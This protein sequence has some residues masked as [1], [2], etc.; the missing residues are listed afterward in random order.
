MAA[1]SSPHISVA[2]EVISNISIPGLPV[3]EFTNAML[4]TLVITILMCGFGI[5]AGK[6]IKT[7]KLTKLQ[8]F[9]EGL[10]M[11]IRES[12]SSNLASD[13][14]ARKYLGLTLTLF[15]FIV[16]G[17]WSGLFPG[18]LSLTLDGIHLFRAPTTDLNAC[19][20]LSLIA[21]GTV[22]YAGFEALGFAG[23]M[24]KF[25]TFKTGP[26][27]FLVGILEFFLEFARLISYSF[28]LFGNIF[29]GEVLLIV[30]SFLTKSFF[31]PIPA[32]VIIMEIGV[33]M[34]QGY[35]LISL[36]SVFIKLA[37]ES[38]HSNDSHAESHA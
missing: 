2:A 12:T 37:T 8:N 30:L 32:L 3:I 26:I 20:A 7:K 13:A 21:F 14:K 10:L 22:Q 38:H 19:I 34:I 31:V 23:Y 15:L 24:G 28:R 25:F 6:M 27:G 16:L 1:E 33:A 29:A 17:S 18:V 5:I 11:F 35:V 9:L 36:M 4:T